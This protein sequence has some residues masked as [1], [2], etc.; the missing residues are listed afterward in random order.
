MFKPA[1]VQTFLKLEK[2]EVLS[3]TAENSS[4]LIRDAVL[5]GVMLIAFR[6]IRSPSS[7]RPS[8]PRRIKT[9]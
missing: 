5:F 9:S 7:S 8:S 4:L 1:G 2:L 3:A 6:K